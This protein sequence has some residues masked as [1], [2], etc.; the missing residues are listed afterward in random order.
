MDNVDIQNQVIKNY[1]S[2]L[3]AIKE[4]YTG[5]N[6]YEKYMCRLSTELRIF[7]SHHEKYGE[8]LKE[9]INDFIKNYKGLEV[10]NFLGT[11]NYYDTDLHKFVDINT[12]TFYIFVNTKDVPERE[13]VIRTRIDNAKC[14]HVLVEAKDTCLYLPHDGDISFKELADKINSIELDSI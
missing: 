11:D 13:L 10:V 3:R 2:E 5:Q 7:V 1:K 6:L 8:G 4:K 14:E 9:P 12:E